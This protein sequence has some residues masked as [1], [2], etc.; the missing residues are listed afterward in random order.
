MIRKEKKARYLFLP[1]SKCVYT[2]IAIMIHEFSMPTQLLN[3]HSPNKNSYNFLFCNFKL[4]KH[5][6]F[7]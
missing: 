5:I 4:D 6:A 1:L 3:G 7:P 2:L